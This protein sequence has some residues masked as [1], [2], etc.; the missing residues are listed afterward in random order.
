MV[1]SVKSISG[2]GFLSTTALLITSSR[3][4]IVLDPMMLPVTSFGFV[5]SPFTQRTEYAANIRMLIS[6]GEWESPKTE[7]LITRGASEIQ[8]K[9]TT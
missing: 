1:C 2:T 5:K 8:D 3:S 6:E 4:S 7:R 9:E